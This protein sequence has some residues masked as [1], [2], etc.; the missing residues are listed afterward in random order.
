METSINKPCGLVCD[1][2]LCCRNALTEMTY[3]LMGFI[4]PICHLSVLGNSQRMANDVVIKMSFSVN[5]SWIQ[6]DLA[7]LITEQSS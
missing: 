7:L 2:Q 3:L 4:E 6:V 5:P 1:G